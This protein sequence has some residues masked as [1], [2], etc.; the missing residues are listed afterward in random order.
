[1]S[2]RGWRRTVDDPF[3]NLLRKSHLPAQTLKIRI[4]F[5]KVPDAPK[6]TTVAPRVLCSFSASELF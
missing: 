5:K 2:E 4:C 1:M 3:A 6:Q